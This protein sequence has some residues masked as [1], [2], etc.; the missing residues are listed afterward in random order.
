MAAIA[1]VTLDNLSFSAGD[2]LIVDASDDS[3][4]GGQTAAAILR[5]LF[6]RGVHVYS[7]DRLHAKFVIVDDCLFVSSANASV[8]SERD[9][10]EAGIMTDSASACASSIA[11]FE[12]LKRASIRI[13]EAFV[14]R[15]EKIPVVRSASPRRTSKPVTSSNRPL[16]TW[17]LGV[18]AIEDPK[19]PKERQQIERALLSVKRALTDAE[20]ELSWCS[21]GKK[22]RVGKEAAVGDTAIFI[23][24]GSS[25]AEPDRVYRHQPIRRNQSFEKVNRLI[26]CQTAEDEKSSL[27]WLQFKKLCK[28]VGLKEPTKDMQRVV[29]AQQSE[30]LD[31]LWDTAKPVRRIKPS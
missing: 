2:V 28:R 24:R 29:T 25:R 20:T 15:I 1:Y 22:S 4:G 9:L 19:D 27:T 18:H 8:S 16:R 17:L 10:F 23:W 7:Y 31:Q 6:D 12:N 21:F 5:Q 26:Y 13:D 14:R 11:V 30:Q 3:V